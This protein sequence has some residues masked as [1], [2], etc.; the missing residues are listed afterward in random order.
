MN[1]IALTSKMP[2]E[3]RYAS[4]S[5]T[6]QRGEIML[7]HEC[8]GCGF[9]RINR[10]AADDNGFAVLSVLNRSFSLTEEVR[11]ELQNKGINLLGKE[12][13]EFVR[14]QFEGI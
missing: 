5:G 9:H 7:V 14:V 13:I 2:K 4:P 1:A 6:A 10:I 3:N 8:T 12:D 11:I